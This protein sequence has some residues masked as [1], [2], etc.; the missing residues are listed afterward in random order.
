MALDPTSP[1]LAAISADAPAGKDLA[2]DPRFERLS[3][4]LEKLSALTAEAPDWAYVIAECERVLRDD[5]KDLRAMTWLAVAKAQVQGWRGV[6]EGIALCVALSKAYWPLLHP[7]LKRI[8]A[9]AGQIDWLWRAL[10]KRVTAM[11]VGP[12][13][14]DTVRALESLVAEAGASFA[15][16]LQN[17]D[18]GISP[19]RLSVREKIRS[20]PD[21]PEPV[22]LPPPPSAAT[23]NKPNGPTPAAPPPAIAPE[24]APA[25]APEIAN[26]AFDPS[27]LSGL[28]SAQDSAR[29]LREPL[30]A[31]ARH[32]RHLAPTSPWPYRMARV[33]AWLTVEHAPEVEQGKTFLRGPKDHDREEI[34]TLLHAGQWDALLDAAEDAV[35]NHVF[36][37]DPHRFS[38]IALEKKGAEYRAA[39]QAVGRELVAF[40][41]RAPGILHLLFSTGTPFAAP[42]TLDWIEQEMAIV[43]GSATGPVPSAVHAVDPASEKIMSDMIAE[44]ASGNVDDAL[45]DALANAER[46]SDARSRFR[47]H[48][49]VAKQA[50]A[51]ARIDLALALYGRILPQVTETL[52]QWEPTLSAEAFEGFL[53]TMRISS[54]KIHAESTNVPSRD[55]TEISVFQR[56]LAVDPR[57]ALR[58]R[59]QND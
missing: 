45:G 4:E 7:P 25:I 33:A 1:L 24:T 34:T 37:L 10:A 13:E 52:E 27:S 56:L 40:L 14:A 31:I 12:A 21:L 20:L 48:L 15:D 43:G 58:L 26:I 32:A 23:S 5:S 22:A 51:S 46:L 36:W 2:Y 19:L 39:R 18:P 28:D 55:S 50:Q 54:R 42:D 8:R 11:P 53:K 59:W 35:G 57:A 47:V 29:K 49:A 6:A 30:A 41:K 9:R 38:A 17:A 44:L 3:A 16:L